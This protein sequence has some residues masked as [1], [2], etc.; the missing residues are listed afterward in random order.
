MNF[1]EEIKWRTETV[2]EII[3]SYLPAEAG[4]QKSII[5][6]INYNMTAGGKRIRPLLMLETYRMFGGESEVIK[7][8][9]AA[10][11][12]IHTQSLIH[13]DLP[14]LDNDDYRRGRKTTHI[15][16]GE[17][18]GI[19]AGDGLLNFA[20]ETAAKAFKLEPG[21]VNIGKALGILADKSGIYGMLGGQSVDVESV[22][23]PL[24]KEKLDFIYRLKTAALIEGSMMIGAVLAGA[25]E[26]A[27]EKIEKIAA[28]VGLAFQI[29]DD[30]L[31]VESTTEV[32]GKPVLSDEK[33]DKTTYVSI[34]GIEKAKAD[35]EQ[36]S[37]LAIAELDSLDVKN[38]FLRDLIL[39]MINREK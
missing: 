12:M 19:L 6:A 38:D 30:I 34:E 26:E 29:R 18:M 33:N 13:D 22:N 17:A 28:N 4:F 21:N 11:E 39:Q 24:S 37:S 9:M 15:V 36:V 31:D 25:S 20:Y 8:F 3:E 2:T 23:Q 5:E 35:V 27:V 14:A 7:P 16:F 10:M 32:L 1:N